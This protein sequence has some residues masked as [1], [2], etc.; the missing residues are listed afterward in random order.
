ME[1][2]HLDGLQTESVAESIAVER[3][4]KGQKH[5][6]EVDEVDHDAPTDAARNR[7]KEESGGTQDGK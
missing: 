5:E 3:V 4:A 7:T 6:G 1:S 2:W